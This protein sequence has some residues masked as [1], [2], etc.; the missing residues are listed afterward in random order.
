MFAIIQ[1]QS[2]DCDESK[3]LKDIKHTRFKNCRTQ[4]DQMRLQR[5][6]TAGSNKELPPL[7]AVPQLN[8]FGPAITS[9]MASA[10]WTRSDRR[11]QLRT[12]FLQELFSNASH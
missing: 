4:L 8:Q 9:F 6:R 3:T 5:Q 10:C 12:S 11:I 2:K 7:P 1:R